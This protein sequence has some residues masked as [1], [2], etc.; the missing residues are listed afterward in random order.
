VRPLERIE[1]ATQERISA[2]LLDGG[3]SGVFA[4]RDLLM[5]CTPLW[6]PVGEAIPSS[7]VVSNRFVY[8][9]TSNDLSPPFLGSLAAFGL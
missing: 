2:A 7:A 3:D 1:A 8:V 9:H 5:I 6:Q 4:R